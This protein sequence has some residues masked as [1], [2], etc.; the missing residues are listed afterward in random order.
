M[1]PLDGVLTKERYVPGAFP[2]SASSSHPYRALWVHLQASRTN[3]N[4][5][6]RLRAAPAAQPQVLQLLCSGPG[7][8]YLVTHGTST[9]RL[10]VRAPSSWLCPVRSS[11]PVPCMSWTFCRPF[12][13]SLLSIVP[14]SESGSNCGPSLCPL[15]EQSKRV[16]LFQVKAGPVLCSDRKT[17]HTVME[18][19]VH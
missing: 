17:G 3:P 2:A 14:S 18:W 6:R 7:L 5:K 19:T 11:C 12:F 15:S 1:L 4:L 9:S 16:S 10:P 8:Y 13:A